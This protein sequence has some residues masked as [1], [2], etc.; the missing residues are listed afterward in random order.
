MTEP[1][2]QIH[3]QGPTFSRVIPGMMRQ[4]EWGLDAAGVR[5]W[6]KAALDM[7]LTT[8]DHADIY[9]SYT[10]EENF[11][12]ALALEP[13]LRDKMQLVTKC[14][15]ILQRGIY[16]DSPVHHYNT[17]REHIIKMAE[18]SLKGLQ[19]D[20]LDVLLIHR[21]D[22]LQDPVE[23][24]AALTELVQAGKTRYVGVSNFTPS[25]FDTLQNVLDIPLVTN[26]VEFSPSHMDPLTDGTFDHAL[27]HQYAPMAWSP[28]GGGGIFTGQSE[29]DKRLREMMG[30]IGEELGG[31]GID[32]VAYAWILKHPAKVMPVTGTG[33]LERLQ[34]AADAMQIDM[35]REQWFRIWEASAGHEVP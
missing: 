2:I 33:K 3:P 21:P 8:F 13:S 28:V 32:Q 5:D 31:K 27:R 11:G 14:G 19:T 6:I 22:P 20:Y 34:A 10:V 16:A 23:V 7:G 18:R 35:S 24:A 26:Q 9:G 29:Q 30:T 15:I 1:T 25:Q 12:A 4:N 17:T